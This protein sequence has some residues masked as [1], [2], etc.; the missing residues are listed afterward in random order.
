MIPAAITK[1]DLAIFALFTLFICL[2]VYPLMLLYVFQKDE[3]G[4]PILGKPISPAKI[5]IFH[6]KGNDDEY[7]QI[8]TG[9]YTLDLQKNELLF[10]GARFSKRTKSY[11][12]KLIENLDPLALDYLAEKERL[13]R[14]MHTQKSWRRAFCVDKAKLRLN[15]RPLRAN[16]PIDGID[17]K[18]KLSFQDYRDLE[19]YMLKQFKTHGLYNSV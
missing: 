19:K 13:E 6:F 3:P 17:K 12:K 18:D 2:I 7:E 8:I 9:A 15:Q 10:G 1:T 14:E 4:N 16:I 11:I 5:H